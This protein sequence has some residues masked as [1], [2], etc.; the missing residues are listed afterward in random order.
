MLQHPEFS[1]FDQ[2]IWEREL[3]QFVP[4]TVFDAHTHIWSNAH[5]KNNNQNSSALRLDISLVDLHAWTLALFPN[6]KL[7]YIPLPTPLKEIDFAGHNDWVAQQ[8]LHAP[9]DIPLPVIPTM[10]VV[11]GMDKEDICMRAKRDG[12][13]VLKPYRVY[14]DDPKNGAITDYFPESFMEAADENRMSVVL[15]LSKETGPADEQNL[16]DLERF[17][18]KYPNMRWILAHCARAFNSAHLEHSIHRLTKM[19]QVFVDTSAVCDTYS[20]YLL[21]KYFDREKILFGTDNVAAGSARGKYITFG[22]G[23]EGYFGKDTI[24]HCDNRCT[25]IVY[26][27]LRCQKQAAEMAGLT[28]SEI[29]DVFYRNGLKYFA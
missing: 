27:Q 23:W 9:A 26:E 8:A 11:P 21:F 4:D 22:Y 25:F 17:T 19:E 5:K 15:H 12:V 29:D 24:E 10:L 1:T 18:K 7:G 28:R 13:K 14:A 3:D 20:H 2:G 6:R 16:A